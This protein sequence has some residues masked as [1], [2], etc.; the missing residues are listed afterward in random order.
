M[1]RIL[2][3]LISLP[4]LL[5]CLLMS[6]CTRVHA[7]TLSLQYAKG[8]TLERRADGILATIQQEGGNGYAARYLLVSK[9]KK[10]A[11]DDRRIQVISVPIRRLATLSTTH[12]SYI[13][14]AGCMDRIVGLSSFEYV[15]TPSA[16]QRIQ[17]GKIKCV[18]SFSNLNLETLMDLSPDLILASSAVS[19]GGIQSKL[20]EA[21]LPVL[22]ITDFMEAH[23][24]G[25]LEWIK[26]LGLLLGTEEHAW[27]V[28]DETAEQYK[29]LA[30]KAS[31]TK[32]RPRVLTGT[33]FQG[34]WWVARGDSYIARLIRDAGGEYLW[35]QLAGT[36]SVPMDV[37][38]VYE[39]ALDADI[40]IN[41]GTWKRLDE[42]PAADPRFDDIPALEKGM[43]YNNNKRINAHGGNDFW[44]SG[45]LHPEKVLADLIAIFHPEL[46]PDHEL[47]YYRQ[48]AR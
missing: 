34:Q 1:N 27:H 37:E 35:S 19:V 6:P 46:L 25:R 30:G 28:F 23:P 14:A 26:F 41:T 45:M 22:M 38:T 15:N 8:F 31:A 10:T 13:D 4:V 43:L 40:W 12:L 32:H 20:E 9:G 3:F 33:P 7:E 44:E 21:G 17:A 29:Q 18:G 16:V 2:F 48:L 47:V 11:I 39:R 24:L 5:P 42:A 36:G